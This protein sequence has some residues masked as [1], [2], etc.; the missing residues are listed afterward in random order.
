MDYDM[1]KGLQA[2]LFFGAALAFPLWQLIA[3]RRDLR[4]SGSKDD[5]QSRGSEPK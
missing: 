2:L 4:R 1:A 5:L 3:V